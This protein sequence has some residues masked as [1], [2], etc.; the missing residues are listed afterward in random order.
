MI[1]ANKCLDHGLVPFV[2]CKS[3]AAGGLWNGFANEIGVWDSLTTNSS[4]YLFTFSDYLWNPEDPVYPTSKQVLAY[5]QGYMEKHDLLQYFHFNSTVIKVSRQGEDYSVKWKN[6]EETKEK[7]FKYVIL[8]SGHCSRDNISIAQREIFKGDIISG[9]DYRNPSVLSGKKVVCVGRSFT[10]SDIALEALKTA[11]RVTQ[12]YSKSYMIMKRFTRDLSHDFFL[13]RSNQAYTPIEIVQSLNS[14]RTFNELLLS[15]F[16]NPS[17]FLS[18]WEIPEPIAE[19]YKFVVQSDNYLEAIR[20]KRI[21]QVKGRVTDFFA[22]GVILSD[23]TQLEA[24]IIVLA[25]GYVADFSYLSEEIKSII[26]YK[27]DDH[28]L[29]TILYRS[30]FHPSL[31]RL[32]FVGL[33][34]GASPGRF[35]LPAEVGIRYLLGE[36]GISEEEVWQ[37]VRDEEF[38]RENLRELNYPYG[39]FDYF[40]ELI[41]ILGIKI[42]FDVVRNE[43]G[44]YNGPLL[45]QM[46]WLERPEQVELSKQVIAEIKNIFPQHVF[47]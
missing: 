19:F 22:D 43:L 13:F 12:V 5:L 4:K 44:F 6:D 34:V 24:D 16:G 41:R 28:L 39:F 31:P 47:S 21:E 25:T 7:E 33:L 35:E 36:L 18:E 8:A 1:S 17:Q 3:P 46:L 45:P 14:N 11:A 23:G 9:G 26:Q 20:S 15:L 2:L 30:L 38:I 27:E 37:G 32:C 10:A 42:D 29:S 40:K